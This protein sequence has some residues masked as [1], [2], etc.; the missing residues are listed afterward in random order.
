MSLRKRSASHFHCPTRSGCSSL[1]FLLNQV[2]LG[3]IGGDL[4]KAV[5]IAREQPGKRTEAVAS[6]LIDRVTGLF[7]MLLVA[8]VGYVLASRHIDFGATLIALART[9]MTL[10]A[11]GAVGLALLISPWFPAQKLAQLVA[12]VPKIGPTLVR[13]IES[14][15]AY[16]RHRI[17]LMAAILM[18]CVTHTLFALALWNIGR[19]LP[20]DAPELGTMFVVVPLSLA[21]AAIP[22][23]PS[24]L[25]TFEAAMDALFVAAGCPG[26]SGFLVAIVYRVMTYVM[27]VVGAVYYV[28]ARRTVAQVLHEAEENADAVAAER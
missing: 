16:R 22:L 23:T 1:G 21:A 11:I 25:G 3:S 9:V 7:A 5:F 13:L 17:R 6:V 19:A 24:G 20:I 8:T 12:D 2:S 10:F 28:N 27:A 26:A 14:A 4:F 18:S 15:T